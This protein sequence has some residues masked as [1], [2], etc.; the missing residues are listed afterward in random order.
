[1]RPTFL[2]ANRL[3]SY[4]RM[5]ENVP[6][7]FTSHST[8]L[9][10]HRRWRKT[11]AG[12]AGR[13]GTRGIHR[14]LSRP[15]PRFQAAAYYAAVHRM[16]EAIGRILDQV[17]QAGEEDNTIVIFLSDNGGSGNGGNAPLRGAKSSMWEGGLRVPFLMRWPSRLEGGQVNDQFLT[18]L[19]SCRLSCR[20][21]ERRSQANSCL[22]ASICSKSCAASNPHRARKCSGSVERIGA[23]RIGYWKWLDSAKGKGLYDLRTD[24][25]ESEDLSS[26]NPKSFA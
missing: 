5:P 8:P 10:E 1:M 19:E 6:I 25:G 9:T 17:R 24:L 3:R 11:M 16:D 7:F 4:N 12:R 26:K 20:R 15:R 14:T 21:L 2:N 18:S 22:M 13:P 23:A